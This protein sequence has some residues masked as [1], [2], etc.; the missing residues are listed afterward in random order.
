M[1]PD[2]K[3]GASGGGEGKTVNANT[4]LMA[5]AIA[6]TTNTGRFP[7]PKRASKDPPPSD[8][9]ICGITI[10]KFK[11]PIESPVNKQKE[12]NTLKVKFK[13]YVIKGNY[14]YLW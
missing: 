1:A 4:P 3:A 10:A 14:F 13:Y 6:P 12:R 11:T 8:T 7:P 2:F 5:A 9:I